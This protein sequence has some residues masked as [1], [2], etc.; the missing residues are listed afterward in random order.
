M[1]G[2]V[3]WV[4]YFWNTRGFYNYI[5]VLTV[6]N[7]T[8]QVLNWYRT[9]EL[10]LGLNLDLFGLELEPRFEEIDGMDSEYNQLID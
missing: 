9:R 8:F 1:G 5:E 3:R 6:K 7:F 2:L 4:G 10:D